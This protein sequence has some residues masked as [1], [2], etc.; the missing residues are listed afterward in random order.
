M[1]LTKIKNFQNI[2]KTNSNTNTYN[3]NLLSNKTKNI[4]SDYIEHLNKN[5]L[6][7]Y[8][9]KIIEIYSKILEYFYFEN[10]K[11]IEFHL[12]H[13]YKFKFINDLVFAKFMDKYNYSFVDNKVKLNK[14]ISL[15]SSFLDNYEIFYKLNIKN[16]KNNNIIEISTSP[17][18]FEVFTYFQLNFNIYKN[19]NYEVYYSD[20]NYL[21]KPKKTW[22]K[23]ID[24]LK[25]EF[26]NIDFIYNDIFKDLEHNYDFMILDLNQYKHRVGDHIL[27]D[28]YNNITNIYFQL[29]YIN[30]L[31]K[32]G[33]CLF[34]INNLL[35]PE[36]INVFIYL[37]HIFKNIEILGRT[38]LSLKKYTGGV[39]L[40]CQ[41]KGSYQINI[42][43]IIHKIK[44]WNMNEEKKNINIY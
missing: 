30:F 8:T 23:N 31:N 27:S 2:I 6:N 20:L 7:N 4:F 26:K 10:P 44:K 14:Y 3:S 17:D 22:L 37:S 18:F 16:F 32:N 9:L 19:T 21:H 5:I 41:N 1:N 15:S 13:Y 36:T 12:N 33:S 39:W 25:K 29:H 40:Y 35:I 24:N 34:Y 42:N 38:E 11:E 28:T 43:K